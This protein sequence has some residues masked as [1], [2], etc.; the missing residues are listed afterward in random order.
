MKFSKYM[1]WLAVAAMAFLAMAASSPQCARTSDL[2]VN[3]SLETL[4]DGNP[5]VQGCIDN[6]QSAM[7]AE[8]I[9]FK[10]AMAACNSD[11][12]CRYQESLTHE[13]N[14][15]ELVADKDACIVVCEHQ[16]GEGAGG[17]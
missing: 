3:P 17:Q 6:F 11:S 16:Q 2:S 4:S 5:C 9:R 8:K 7:Q 12:D 10:D 15:D 13:T 1:P 14:V